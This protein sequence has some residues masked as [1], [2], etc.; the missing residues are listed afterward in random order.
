VEEGFKKYTFTYVDEQKKWLIETLRELP[1]FVDIEE[2]TLHRIVYQMKR[3]ILDKGTL[4]YKAQEE[5]NHFRIVQDGI[6]DVFTFF[7]GKEFI[8]ERL[9]RGS[10]MNHRSF[11]LEEHAVVFARA[12]KTSIVLEISIDDINKYLNDSPVF[13]KK[14]L[15]YQT[16]ILNTGKQFPVD[17]LLRVPEQNI[18]DPATTTPERIGR[19]NL[20]KL[21]VMR[22]IQELRIQKSKPKLSD[23]LKEL[24]RGGP[25]QKMEVKRK[26]LALYEFDDEEKA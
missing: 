5:V 13:E 15:T 22:R 12:A 4:L 21:A 2:W 16:K 14:F 6:I 10:L 17:Y 9:M 1:F 3:R 7:E 8:I 23:L 24:K 25:V 26:I 11:F 20:F 19:M 18:I